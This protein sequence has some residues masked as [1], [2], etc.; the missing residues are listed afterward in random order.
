MKLSNIVTAKDARDLVQHL[1]DTVESLSFAGE[2]YR[3]VLPDE[4]RFY[5]I[6]FDRMQKDLELALNVI[7][8]EL[9]DIER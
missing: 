8:L 2:L 3:K 5:R 7:R 6:D 9:D 4:T 1:S